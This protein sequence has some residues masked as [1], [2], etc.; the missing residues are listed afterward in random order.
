MKKIILLIGF[1]LCIVCYSCS[2][3]Q[4][5]LYLETW[6]SQDDTIS[7]TFEIIDIDSISFL[8][9]N[10]IILK[11]IDEPNYYFVLIE[12]ERFTIETFRRNTLKLKLVKL[13]CNYPLMLKSRMSRIDIIFYDKSV[14]AT[15][16][17]IKNR[18]VVDAFQIID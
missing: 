1:L 16:L 12:I 7:S 14:G 10:N 4:T 6:Y 11:G 5:N 2:S 13:P 18:V 9:Y 15:I 8:D 17:W 3:S